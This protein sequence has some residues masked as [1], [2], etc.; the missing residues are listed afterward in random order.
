ML[1]DILESAVESIDVGPSSKRGQWIV[2]VLFGTLGLALSVAGAYKMLVIGVDGASTHFNIASSLIFFALGAFCLFN[3][4][5]ARPWRW[6]GLAFVLSFVVL[7]LV[8]VLF[9]A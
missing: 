3:V 2:R 8:R 9:G 7:F 1:D 6:P 4:I 5:L